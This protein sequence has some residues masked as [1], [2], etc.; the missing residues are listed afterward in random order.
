MKLYQCHKQVKAKPMT[1]GEYNAYREWAMPEDED[2][3]APGF[4]VEYL[5]GGKPNHPN[6]EG[7]ISWSP[8]HAF[9]SGYTEIPA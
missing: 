2:P 9:D 5:D 6:H 1:L 8:K 3:N 4:L 7:Y